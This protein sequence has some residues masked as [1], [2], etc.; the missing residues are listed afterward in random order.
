MPGDRTQSVFPEDPTG[1]VKSFEC[2]NLSFLNYLHATSPAGVDHPTGPGP[3]AEHMY[4][5]ERSAPQIDVAQIC[6]SIFDMKTGDDDGACK[7][8]A[9]LEKSEQLN[10]LVLMAFYSGSF[11]ASLL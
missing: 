5:D 8:Q 4:C 7:P 1:R 3:L 9:P 10:T 2:T 11:V 6:P